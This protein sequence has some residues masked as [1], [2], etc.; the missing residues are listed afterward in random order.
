M[1]A[2]WS[3]R[4]VFVQESVYERVV[5]ALS[6]KGR[7][8]AA[9]DRPTQYLEAFE[10]RR[11]IVAV[12]VGSSAPD[13]VRV[14]TY[15]TVRDLLSLLGTSPFLSL[16]CE[17]AAQANEL[18][19]LVTSN[20]VWING[21]A[22]FDGPPELALAVYDVCSVRNMEQTC[23]DHIVR[24]IPE[25]S[26]LPSE[27]RKSIVL[28][29]LDK[30]AS[31]NSSKSSE[32]S[33]ENESIDILEVYRSI[34]NWK[35]RDQVQMQSDKITIIVDRPDPNSIYKFNISDLVNALKCVIRGYGTCVICREGDLC[36]ALISNMILVDI[37]LLALDS[38][39]DFY[40]IVWSRVKPGITF[41]GKTHPGKK[42]VIQ[43]TFGTIM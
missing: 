14:L 28:D 7:R 16:W 12:T 32:Q 42:K 13:V 8:M 18:A 20:Y 3:I 33:E 37:P 21:Y 31:D 41:L 15:R 1:Q 9:D 29:V 22:D 19:S 27:E 24:L 43:T 4:R 17:D 30:F 26:P 34:E 35:P 2:P 11:G 5:A 10:T 25:W 39:S 40:S 36:Q 6:A 38:V 23:C